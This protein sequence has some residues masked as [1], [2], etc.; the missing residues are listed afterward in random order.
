MFFKFLIKKINILKLCQYYLYKLKRLRETN[1]NILIYLTKKKQKKQLSRHLT[2]IS[3]IFYSNLL[4]GGES[5]LVEPSRGALIDTLGA[6]Q[7]QPSN[8]LIQL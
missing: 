4:N 8:S 5:G 6:L 2:H 3:N 1:E 7:D